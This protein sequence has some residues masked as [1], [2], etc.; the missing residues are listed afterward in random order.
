MG[1]AFLPDD[2]DDDL[3]D[4]SEGSVEA[5][6]TCPPSADSPMPCLFAPE[7]MDD[8]DEP[9]S[10]A[11]IMREKYLRNG[12]QLPPSLT[13]KRP[14]GKVLQV[15]QFDTSAKPGPDG[16]YRCESCEAVYET[17]TRFFGHARFC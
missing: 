15:V 9:Q 13:R 5:E 6:A 4:V 11:E 10:L 12:Q 16:R 14:R 17:R 2:L 7:G 8:D 3:D 1:D